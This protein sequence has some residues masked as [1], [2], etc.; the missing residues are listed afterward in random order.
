V[1]PWFQQGGCLP[2]GGQGQFPW[3]THMMPYGAVPPY[4]A[5]PGG[6]WAAYM[7]ADQRLAMQQCS[8]RLQP[9]SPR[10]AEQ[11]GPTGGLPANSGMPGEVSGAAVDPKKESLLP[12]RPCR[13]RCNRRCRKPSFKANPCGGLSCSAIAQGL[14]RSLQST[15][16]PCINAPVV[17]SGRWRLWVL[18]AIG[19]TAIGSLLAALLDDPPHLM[20]AGLAAALGWLACYT[21]ALQLDSWRLARAAGLDLARQVAG[22]GEKEDVAP[23]VEASAPNGGMDLDVTG[24]AR[25]LGSPFCAGLGTAAPGRDKSGQTMQ[26]VLTSALVNEYIRCSSMLQKYQSR[27]GILPNA[28]QCNPAFAEALLTGLNG[29][30]GAAGSPSPAGSP[31]PPGHQ[32]PQNVCPV[33]VGT[34]SPVAGASGG[35]PNFADRLAAVNAEMSPRAAG[36][37]L[38]GSASSS[39]HEGGAQQ[40]A[41]SELLGQASGS[42][43]TV[44]S[45]P[46]PPP[47]SELDRCHTIDNTPGFSPRANAQASPEG[48]GPAPRSSARQENLDNSIND[49]PWLRQIR[50]A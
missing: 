12:C 24:L 11:V 28:P 34:A 27:H 48:K 2:P 14:C 4:G 43:R 42:P 5:Y 41:L 47:S 49:P 45:V 18:A 10:L 3:P 46:P 50:R 13:W 44:S 7:P 35:T 37:V 9:C 32:S 30:S 20:A 40:R 19:L 6:D 25:S 23:P 8:P 16:A 29:S 33:E 38:G 15:G 31:A 17:Q 36:T 22:G 21:Y 39:S 1:P 26:A